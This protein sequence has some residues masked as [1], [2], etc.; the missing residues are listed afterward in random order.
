MDK[1]ENRLL[2][3]VE[4]KADKQEIKDDFKLKVNF[5]DL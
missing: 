4:L 5:T 3:Q 2:L 1:L